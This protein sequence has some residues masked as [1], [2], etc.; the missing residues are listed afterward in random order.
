MR[1]RRRSKR[2]PF[3]GRCAAGAAPSML[4]SQWP[5]SPSVGRSRS[6]GRQPWP[7]SRLR[8]WQPVQPM[9]GAATG[10]RCAAAWPVGRFR[11]PVAP[12]AQ[13]L[14][15]ERSRR[16][17]RDAGSQWPWPVGR[18]S[19]SVGRCASMLAAD[20]RCAVQPLGWPVR[21]DAGST[22]CAWPV[23]PLAAVAGCG[24]QPLGWPFAFDWT[25][26]VAVQP[27]SMLATS[28]R[29]RLAGALRWPVQPWP[30][31]VRSPSVGRSRSIGRQPWPCS[32]LR[33]WQ[34]VQPMAGAR[35]SPS[36]GRC[37][38]MLAV[39]SVHGR[40][41]H[42]QPWPVRCSPSVRVRLDANRGRAAA[43]DAGSRCGAQPL[44]WPVRFDAGSRGRCAA[45]RWPVQPVR[46]WQPVR[47]RLAGWPFSVSRGTA[48]PNASQRAF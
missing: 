31:A 45:L 43:F 15:R 30:V 47:S 39:P 34:P 10:S 19:P 12:L 38:S 32:R 11:Y 14:L 9:A 41:S 3:D 18:C 29:G 4:A 1:R 17:V 5:C 2:S 48:S 13:T 42:W 37:A 40:C 7:C 28:G 44:G 16:L 25:P 21:F 6:I 36:V 22:E 24:A 35:C 46:C 8:C 33:C 20:G 27:P 26:T 23:Q